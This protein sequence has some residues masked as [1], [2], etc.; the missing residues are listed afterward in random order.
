MPRFVISLVLVVGT[1]FWDKV[2]DQTVVSTY[3]V[4]GWFISG[5]LL[6]NIVQN[7][8][9]I[10]K[11]DVLMGLGEFIKN[12]TKTETGIELHNTTENEPHTA[13]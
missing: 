7:G 10:T 12:R 8:Y 3:K 2:F 9:R 1:F 13:N 6:A 4:C 5:V 11:W